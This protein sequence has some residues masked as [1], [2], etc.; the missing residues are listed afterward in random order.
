MKRFGRSLILTS[1]VMILLL[2]ALAPLAVF[3]ARGGEPQRPQ[4]QE[5]HYPIRLKT[6]TFTPT[7]GQ[8]PAVP[9][10]LK[11]SGYDAAQQGYY[12][13]QFRGPVAQPW[14]DE[15]A[16]LGVELLT[17]VPDF[18]FKVRMTPAQAAQVRKLDS[19]GWVGFFHP[20]Y[21]LN[22][23]LA[24]SEEQAL[25]QVQIARGAD[26]AVSRRAIKRLGVEVLSREGRTLLVAADAT[27]LE[28]L[29]QILDVAWVDNFVLYETH[30]EYGGG[31][32]M[33]ANAAFASGYDGSSQTVAVADTGL[34]GGTASTAH[35]DIPSSRITAIYNW[36]GVSDS[37]WT[38]YD[39]GAQDVDS[40]HG[41][42]TALSVASDGGP[43]GEG[44]G[45]APAANL[46][47]Q[48]VENYADMKGFC[49]FMYP[50][51]YYLT[52]LPAVI[53]DLFQEAYDAGARIHSNSWGSAAAGEYTEDSQGADD[54]IWTHP[55]MLIT[56][57]AGNDGIDGNSD[58]VIDSDS[59]GAPAT[60]KNVL[61]VGASEND[62][63]GDWACDS[64]LS[65]CSGQNDIFTWGAA[66]PSDYPANPIKDDPSAGG[67]QQMAAFSSRG[68]TDDGRIKPDVVAPGSWVLSGYSDMYQEGYD[69]SANPQNGAWQYDGYGYPLDAYYKYMSG[70]S[71]SNPLAAGAA[72]TVRDYYNKAHAIDASAALVKA[73]LVNSAVDLLDENNDG[74]DD[75]DYPIPNVHEGWGLIDLANATD[76]TAQFVDDSG[77]LGTGGSVS[78]QFSVSSSGAPFKVTAV[79]SDYPSATGVSKNLVNDLDLE[80]TSP[81]GSV[82]KGNVFSGGWSYAGGSAD[83]TN[84]V[85]NV[86]VASAEAGTWTVTISGYNVPQGPQP[87]A[88]VVDGEF[89]AAPPTPTPTTPPPTATAT[90]VPPT[91]TPAPPT[92][93]SEPPTATPVPPT[94]TSAPPTATPTPVPPTPT[95]TPEPAGTMHVGDLDGS[96]YSYNRWRWDA[97]VVITVHD[98]AHGAVSGATVSGTWSGGYSGS[99]S[100]VTDSSGQCSV[101]SGRI[102]KWF[103][104]ETFTV[105]N[106]THTEFE[107][108]A[109]ANH[110]PDGSSDGTT[111][112]I[113]AP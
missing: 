30:N 29:A 108:D 70:T 48:A 35:R 84:N 55:D 106:V 80:V 64:G 98:D 47:F 23:D 94:P 112:T 52:G 62:R 88:L 51:G 21:K 1:V 92:P 109:T 5:Q 32:I 79:W 91:A 99:A 67:A 13:V 37:C 73:T 100:C 69:S 71:M 103:G 16:G 2:T 53:G 72:A 96:T 46:V 95:A 6:A 34:G 63:D 22:P 83:R 104:S 81:G 110:D 89:G 25:Y 41:T 68:P 28:A 77:G 113:S 76:G 86:Y 44:Q 33:G 58:G 3:S 8:A 36:P 40:G 20:A 57:S 75:N 45:T 4:A 14:K 26:A 49:G 9:A 27:Q 102:F 66:W 78:Y 97:T 42:H 24:S 60:A 82:Y 56:F 93:T 38:V 90:P 50:D 111:I 74:V 31:G 101:T 85:E 54:F 18:A 43:N 11:I 107:Y 19:V 39:D 87:F 105:D 10:R 61:T 17:Y 65:G 59:M 7:R 12:L 15:V